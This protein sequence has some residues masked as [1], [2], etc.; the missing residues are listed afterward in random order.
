MIVEVHLPPISR[1]VVAILFDICIWQTE[2]KLIPKRCFLIF[3]AQ[4]GVNFNV[5]GHLE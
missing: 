4:R 5:H 2:W 1:D 3:G